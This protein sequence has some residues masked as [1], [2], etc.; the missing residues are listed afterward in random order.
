MLR[1]QAGPATRTPEARLSELI[2]GGFTMIVGILGTDGYSRSL[3]G[4]LAK[5]RGLTEEGVTAYM[6][7]GCY[8][9][10]PPT[11]TGSITKDIMTV[12]QVIGVG[13]IAVSDHRG[14]QPSRTDLVAVASECRVAGMLSGKCGLVHVHIGPGK[15]LLGP[16]FDVVQNTDIPITQ[17]LPT[18]MDRSEELIADG[19]RWLAEG[20]NLDFTGRSVRCRIALKDYDAKGLLRDNGEGD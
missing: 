6:W 11:I 5:C 1:S 3:E 7:T 19:A 12:E 2:N 20:G 16:L 17:F 13:E 10:P 18:H 4:L 14:S 8:R 9:V 15:G